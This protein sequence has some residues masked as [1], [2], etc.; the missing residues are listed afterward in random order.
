MR[1]AY[2]RES[3]RRAG[4]GTE[5]AYRSLRP[6]Y[7]AWMALAS[8]SARLGQGR[9]L[10]S[11]GEQVTDYFPRLAWSVLV[12]CGCRKNC[13]GLQP[14]VFDEPVIFMLPAHRDR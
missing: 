8:W 6:G 12:N 9:S 2:I 14:A 4:P 5:H 11:V 7:T 3:S 13:H 1:P 10:L